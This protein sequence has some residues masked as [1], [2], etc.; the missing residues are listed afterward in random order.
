MKI[1]VQLLLVDAVF[2]MSACAPDEDTDSAH[3]GES[4][5]ETTAHDNDD[6]PQEGFERLVDATWE[7]APGEEGYR[8]TW[9]TLT[10]DVYI[11]GLRSVSPH[12][13]HHSGVALGPPEREDGE[14][15]CEG[16][17][18]MNPMLFAA[19]VGTNVLDLPDGVGYRLAAGQQIRLDVHYFNPT[20]EPLSGTSGVDARIVPAAEVEQQ[21]GFT[22]AG[23]VQ[24]EISPSGEREEISGTCTLPTD[25][26][27]LNWFPH[28]HELGVHTKIVLNGETI[29]DAP[30]DFEHQITYGDDREL[31]AGDKVEIT[32]TYINDTGA[33]VVSG[34][35]S[36]DEMCFLG[37]YT[38]PPLPSSLCSDG[39][40]L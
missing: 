16:G 30:F 7:A 4:H 9:L 1:L 23:P 15:P 37:M 29:H 22:F 36:T 3:P 17:P 28:A 18:S 19:G 21:V 13:S 20:Q 14:A 2:V 24:F 11:T 40:G 12:G 33:T 39:V 26:T 6:V 35:S 25:V 34:S 31:K 10:E 27:V 5:G 38:V 32:C 8:C